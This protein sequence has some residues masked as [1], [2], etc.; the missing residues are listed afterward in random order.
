MY[1]IKVKFGLLTDDT[2]GQLH[3]AVIL[4]AANTR[5]ERISSY[6][7][8]ATYWGA[9]TPPAPPTAEVPSSLAQVWLNNWQEVTQLSADMFMTPLGALEGY[10]FEAEDF[11]R[12]LAHLQPG[13][14]SSLLVRFGLHQYYQPTP[15]G[16][17][18][19]V[20][21][22]GLVLQLSSATQPTEPMFDISM[23]CPYTC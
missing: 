8:N 15:D 16:T 23:P 5:D 12:P 20:R 18:V 3:F 14:E 13:V 19:A 6:Y 9:A 11:I 4:Y 7:T 2:T 21:T 10:T 17:D 22:F 1:R